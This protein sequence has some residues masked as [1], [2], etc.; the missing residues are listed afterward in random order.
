[1]K[2][3]FYPSITK[4]NSREVSDIISILENIKNGVYEDYVYPVR[5]AKNDKEKKEAKSKAPCI[6]TS[7]TFSQRGND[8]LL[9]HSGLIA[10]DFDH[11]EDI[12]D[13]FNLLINDVYSFAVFRSISGNGLCAF[14][15][16][17]GR[18][19]LE[20]FLGLERYYWQTYN[21]EADRACKDVSRPRYLSY[22]PDLFLNEQ[23]Q[24]FKDYVKRET[25]AEIKA[26]ESFKGG[27]HYQQKFERVLS[28]VN[29][30]ITQGYDNWVKLGFAIASEYGESGLDYFKQ[31]S[32][33]H[34]DYDAYKT[35]KKYR[36]LLG[37]RNS[38]IT[39][40]TF[41][42]LCKLNGIDISDERETKTRQTARKL[43][44][45]G[46][47]EKQVISENPELIPE[48]VAEEFA[49]P[50][51]Q[52]RGQFDIEAFEIWLRERFPIKK[53]EVTRFYEMQG[54]QL[55]QS[56]INTIYIDAKKQFPKVSRDIVE[57]VI[58]SNYTPSYN[59]IKSYFESL[60]WD[61]I[62]HIA[63]LAESINSNTGTEE[64]REFGLRAWLIGI[65]ESI[66][67]GKPNILCL[68]LA[69]KQNTGKSTFFT[70]LLPE[71]LK[72]Y[73][74]MSQLDR[75]KDDEI[76]M[77]QSLLIFDDEFSG[78]SKQDAKHMKRILSAPS[79]TLREPYGRNNVTLKRIATLCGTC[80]ELDV[81]NDPT[82]NR[83]FIVFE[84]VGQFDYK[85]YNSIDKNQLFAQCVEL[86]NN[87]LTSDL[88]GDFVNLMEQVS[89]DFLEISI[90]EELLLQHFNAN[91]T[92]VR[93][94]QWMPTTMIK[95]YLEE[96][97]N[98][99]LSIKRLGQMLR[100]HNFERIKRNNSY[101]YM[102]AAIYLTQK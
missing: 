83:R 61:G 16:I 96:N 68:V 82:G 59:P 11:L 40:R 3:S 17:D 74:A 29:C 53:N 67:K 57:S 66:L 90:E 24:P 91:D 23:S 37:D 28:R 52:H 18:K 101:G 20:A 36:S 102:V 75:G 26:F 70:R 49:K 21:L 14:V 55:E 50:E 77:C 89:E 42:Y 93:T 35:E 8:Y 81:L 27:D 6:T 4:T 48:I 79:F 84:V 45:A 54:K 72:R 73:F 19:H 94:R 47:T 9:Q 71:H 63:K 58:F 62:D 38:G 44:T 10:I 97:S 64:Y 51:Q 100:K 99:K 69:G 31:L 22:D 7:G 30:D 78:K 15:K 95:D 87:G 76:L 85:L 13:A 43:K 2:V 39:I 80:N 41:Y 5:N 32:Q 60:K 98:Q 34:P 92:N 12:G 65:V 56:D 46:K 86:V 88:E 25:K 33:Y 1:M